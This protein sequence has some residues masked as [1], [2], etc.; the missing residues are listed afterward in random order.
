MSKV[1][2]Y[3]S[4]TAKIKHKDGLYYMVTDV[5]AKERNLGHGTGVMH[6]VCEFADKNNMDLYLQVRPYTTLGDAVILDFESLSVFYQ[7]F[8]FEFVGAISMKR[9]AKKTDPIVRKKQR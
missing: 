9:L 4:A 7:K 1:F 5:I 6:K 8:G 2:E 3:K